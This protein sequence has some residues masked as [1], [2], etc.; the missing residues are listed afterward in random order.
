[1]HINVFNSWKELGVHRGSSDADIKAA[2]KVLAMKHHPDRPGSDPG[3]FER[4]TKAHSLLKGVARLRSI[5]EMK[6]LG[7][8]CATCD[9]LG[10]KRKQKGF[11]HVEISGCVFCGGAGYVQRG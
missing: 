9:G 3:M 8:P 2:Y 11:K 7:V 4:I 10:V 6:L 5:E 1:M